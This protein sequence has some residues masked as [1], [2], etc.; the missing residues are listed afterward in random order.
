MVCFYDVFV[1]DFPDIFMGVVV[2][3]RESIK[4]TIMYGKTSIA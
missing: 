1:S 4:C 3:N 2:L